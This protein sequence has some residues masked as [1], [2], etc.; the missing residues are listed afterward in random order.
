MVKLLKYR[1]VSSLHYKSRYIDNI[2]F[3]HE[4]LILHT[5]KTDKA[6]FYLS[7]ND[8]YIQNSPKILTE[9][10]LT[11]LTTVSKQYNKLERSDN[12]L[13]L[14]SEV[15]SSKAYNLYLNTKLCGFS[16]EDGFCITYENQVVF[17][18]LFELRLKAKLRDSKFNFYSVKNFFF[19][20]YART[21]NLPHYESLLA[22]NRELHAEG[23]N[24]PIKELINL[25]KK[26]KIVGK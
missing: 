4:G 8:A 18:D 17:Y 24:I 9:L 23:I 25:S 2:I 15:D 14:E 26:Y 20:T 7:V 16:F 21:E 12:F 19:S 10:E 13:V 11:E 3:Y 1:N 6:C 22:L 5:I